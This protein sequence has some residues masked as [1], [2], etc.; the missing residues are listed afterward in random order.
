[1]IESL[2]FRLQPSAALLAIA[3]LTAL[4]L[5]G[6]IRP[7]TVR[8]SA[9]K[10]QQPQFQQP[11]VIPT[12]NWPAGIESAELNGDGRPK[13]NRL[14]AKTSHVV[15]GVPSTVLFTVTTPATLF[16]G[17]DVDGTAQ[18]TSSDNSPLTGTVTF[19]D[20][21]TN[22]CVIPVKQN[23][24]CPAAT[25]SGFLSGRHLLSAVYSGDQTHSAATSTTVTVAILSDVTTAILT[26]SLDSGPAGQGVVLTAALHGNFA[27]P[28]GPVTFFDGSVVLGT[29][30]LN[31]SG[32][33]VLATS[34]LTPGT[35]TIT[36]VYAA[37]QNFNA[38]TTNSVNQIITGSANSSPTAIMISSGANPAVAGQ[39]IT[40]S[41][42]V[43]TAGTVAR[44]PSGVV[45]FLDNGVT[46]GTATLNPSGM[47]SFNTSTLATG[48]HIITANYAGDGTSSASSSAAFSQIITSAI[49]PVN[50]SF[51]IGVGSARVPTGGSINVQVK[52]APVNGFN[53]P[54]QLTCS[55]LPRTATCIFA[56]DKVAAGGGTTTFKLT[57]LSPR[58]CGSSIP[59][60]QS[61]SNRIAVLPYE[62]PLLAGT[63]LFFLP[64][65]RRAWRGLLTLIAM[66]GFI[67]VTGCGACTDLGTRPGTY[68]L[69]ITGTSMG[70]TPV[71]ITQNVQVTV[72]P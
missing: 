53:Q 35:H 32:N 61:S 10:A 59:Y 37:T 63:L 6:A 22:I 68:T 52:V 9:I 38:V 8:P 55:N 56:T 64:K 67:A 65:R 34:R 29:V 48:T 66:G 12:G 31:S 27:V 54:V 50:P 69:Q 18:V 1:M 4:P 30:T 19:Y 43:V 49:N 25:G 46:L 3:S 15:T 33:A 42:N 71:T 21:S 14:D 72:T 24:S 60:G 13:L 28:I 16:F 11:S 36:A 58:D 62:A 44:I 20:G 23:V 70:T 47:A 40:L 2:R 17:Q 51:I 39:A 57:T 7:A 26:S 5:S 41:A 45:T